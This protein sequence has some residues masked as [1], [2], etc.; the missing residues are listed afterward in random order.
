VTNWPA[1]PWICNRTPLTPM[2]VCSRGVSSALSSDPTPTST[3]SPIAR[4][5][6]AFGWI[7][8]NDDRACSRRMFRFNESSCL[9]RCKR[10]DPKCVSICCT[11]SPC[12]LFCCVIIWGNNLLCSLKFCT[13]S[14]WSICFIL[15]KFINMNY[16]FDP[17]N[18]Q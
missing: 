7:A 10:R 13:I 16:I 6:G 8:T 12:R 17:I 5:V 15:H 2:E 1:G 18:V 11:N 14:I 3:R 9:C 4:L